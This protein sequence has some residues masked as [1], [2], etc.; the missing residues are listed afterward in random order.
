LQ[1]SNPRRRL[2]TWFEQL[3]FGL[4]Y[5]ESPHMFYLLESIT[6]K[7]IQLISSTII[8]RKGQNTPISVTANYSAGGIP[9]RLGMNF[10]ASLSE[11]HISVMGT[12]S[13]GIVDI[14]R[15]ILVTLPN[16]ETHRAR[17][18]LTSSTS[19]IASHLWGFIKSGILLARGKLFYGAD[20]VWQQFVDELIGTQSATNISSQ[21][22]IRIVELQHELM[23]RSE[24]NEFPD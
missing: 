22:G 16:D 18:I 8:T 11:W 15:D 6:Q 21:R 19:V 9:I 13:I 1:L 5:D 4:F 3:P 2:P 20:V 7:P 12:K 24:I 17:E 10:E 23:N 14:F